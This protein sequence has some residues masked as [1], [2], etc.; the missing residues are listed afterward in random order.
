MYRQGNSLVV[1]FPAWM[2]EQIGVVRGDVIGLE[3]Y[4]G[5]WI[6]CQKMVKREREPEAEGGQVDGS[7]LGKS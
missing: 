3:V 1:S 4:P 6:T 7:K 2:L 5:Q